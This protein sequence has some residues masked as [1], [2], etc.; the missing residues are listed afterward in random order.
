MSDDAVEERVDTTMADRGDGSVEEWDFSSTEEDVTKEEVIAYVETLRSHVMV[1]SKEKELIAVMKE[2]GYVFFGNR[3]SSGTDNGSDQDGGSHSGRAI[4]YKEAFRFRKKDK[5]QILI[6]NQRGDIPNDSADYC[7]L[8]L[9]DGTTI[10]NVK[11]KVQEIWSIPPEE[12][13]LLKASFNQ[14]GRKS[15]GPGT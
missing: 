10:R 4:L 7:Y 3:N 15:F 5:S 8:E 9:S 13:Y 11:D 6:L 12:H 14:P 2:C 1:N